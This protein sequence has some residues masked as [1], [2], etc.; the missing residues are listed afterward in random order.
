[1][2]MNLFVIMTS[3]LQACGGARSVIN[4]ERTSAVE[5]TSS[6]NKNTVGHHTDPVTKWAK[7]LVAPL[8]RASVKFRDPKDV[9]GYKVAV[10]ADD[11]L[12]NI[13]FPVGTPICRQDSSYSQKH[14]PKLLVSWVMNSLM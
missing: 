10:I 11:K 13:R 7:E 8:S 1:M 2:R 12:V 14:A 6:S 9:G 3:L 5:S 4:K